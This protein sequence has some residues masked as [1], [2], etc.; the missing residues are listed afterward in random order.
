M[1]NFDGNG[2]RVGS[3]SQVLRVKPCSHMQIFSPTPIFKNIGPIL[4]CIGE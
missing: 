2:D 3:V 1:L 4:L